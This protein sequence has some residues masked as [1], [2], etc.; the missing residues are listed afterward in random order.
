[1]TP[2]KTAPANKPLTIL[3]LH[4]TNGC[5]GTTGVGGKKMNVA[6]PVDVAPLLHENGTVADNTPA[7]FVHEFT[8]TMRTDVPLNDHDA[9]KQ[10]PRHGCGGRR[11]PRKDRKLS[12]PPPL[13]ANTFMNMLPLTR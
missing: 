5:G 1:M 12:V 3:P 10:L 7:A 11:W 13:V 4:T 8:P 6:F 9:D 2:S